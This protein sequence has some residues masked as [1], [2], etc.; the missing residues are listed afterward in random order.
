MLDFIEYYTEK[1]SAKPS[2]PL[3]EQI[4][5][6]ITWNVFQMDG[7]KF[8]VPESCTCIYRESLDLHTGK[9]I[10]MSYPCEGC[11]SNNPNRH[12]GKYCYVMDWVKGTKIRFIGLM[13]GGLSNV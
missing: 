8:V 9:T 4:A 3:L 12:N 1:F 5:L 6:I 2:G 11:K 7:L 13:S 10:R